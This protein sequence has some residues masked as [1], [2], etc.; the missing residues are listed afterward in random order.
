MTLTQPPVVLIFTHESEYAKYAKYGRNANTG[1]Q[2][3]QLV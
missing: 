3:F 1:E 2:S